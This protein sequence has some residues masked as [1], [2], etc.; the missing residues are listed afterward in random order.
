MEVC[1]P[2]LYS[3]HDIYTVSIAI[4]Q[5]WHDYTVGPLYSACSNIII[6]S[7]YC[8]ISVATSLLKYN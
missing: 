3:N 2:I 8:I 1:G 6:L 5:M 4:K 7:C